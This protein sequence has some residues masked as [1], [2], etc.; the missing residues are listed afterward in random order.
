MPPV[1]V[2][3]NVTGWPGTAAGAELT[4]ATDTAAVMISLAPSR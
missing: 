1:T 3:V 4:R 2:G